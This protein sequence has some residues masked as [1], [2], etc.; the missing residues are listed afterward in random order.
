MTP[1]VLAPCPGR[2]WDTYDVA[3]LDLDGVVYLGEE[4]VESAPPALARARA[5]GMRLAFTTNNA[6]RTPEQVAHRLTAMGVD[7]APDDVVTSAQAAARL[8]A[9]RLPRGAAV[10]VVGA[11]GLRRAVTDVG[12]RIVEG[13]DGALAVVQGY[14]PEVCYA[15]LAEATLAVGRG[16]LWV[17]S[18][19]DTTMPT[20]RGPLPG[21]GAL[22]AV[23]ATATGRS[24]LLAGKPA[25]PLHAEAVR[26]TSAVRPLVVGDRLDTDVLGAVDAGADSLLVLTGVVDAAGLLSAVPGRRPSYLAADLTGL[27]RSQRGTALGVRDSVVCALETGSDGVVDAH[28]WSWACNASGV[29]L[30]RRPEP[31][32]DDEVRSL[33]VLARAV[34][35]ARDEGAEPDLGSALAAHRRAVDGGSAS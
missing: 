23:V 14:H 19:G 27:G 13:A 16:A 10:L 33:R 9:D 34:W 12:L 6:S 29:T 26:R 31:H 3:L 21:N 32:P 2:L 22:L 35:A 5:A 4:V 15:E 25:L 1:G 7:A 30:L 24:P 17:G 20:P 18:N 28:G 8:L 11:E